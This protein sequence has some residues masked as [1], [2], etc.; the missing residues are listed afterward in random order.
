MKLDINH[1]AGRKTN[2]LQRDTILTLMKLI[3]AG[4][5]A[6]D[7]TNTPAQIAATEK[8]LLE[9]AHERE[10]ELL[11]EITDLQWRL[12]CTQEELQKLKTDNAQKW[13]SEV[14]PL[15]KCG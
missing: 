3:T 2:I 4:E 15:F 1:I 13:I 11:H 14:I 7:S 6:A 10:K 9:S 8:S 5:S 12:I